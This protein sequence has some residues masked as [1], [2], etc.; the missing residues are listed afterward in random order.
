MKNEMI[1]NSLDVGWKKKLVVLDL[2]F[3]W[4]KSIFCWY[5][6]NF[7]YFMLKNIK[8]IDVMNFIFFLRVCWFGLYIFL[9]IGFMYYI[10]L[11]IS[12]K[13]FFWNE[14]LR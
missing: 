2:V 11:K 5:I 14:I 12:I 6:F 13:I 9:V 4:W 7:L 3:V 10:F 8:I 1:W